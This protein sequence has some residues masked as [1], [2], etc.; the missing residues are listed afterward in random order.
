MERN[1][2]SSDITNEINNGKFYVLHRDHGFNDGSGWA[3][4]RYV[5]SDINKLNNDD[6]LPVVFSMNCFTGKFN[7][8]ECFAEAFIRRENGGCVGI[9]AASNESYSGYNDALVMGMFDAIWSNPGLNPEFGS[10]GNNVYIQTPPDIY[11][12]GDVLNHGLVRMEETWRGAKS[13]HQYSNEIFIYFGDPAM[14]IWTVQPSI[15]TVNCPTSISPTENSINLTNCSCSDALA[16]LLINEQLIDVVEF[17]NGSATLHF[18]SATY[19]DEAIITIS[20]SNHRPYIINIRFD[21]DL[22][23]PYVAILSPNNEDSVSGIISIFTDVYDK[24]SGIEKVEFHID[25]TLLFTDDNSPYQYD[26]NTNLYPSGSHTIKVIAF[27]NAGNFAED[28]ITVNIPYIPP[29]YAHDYAVIDVIADPQNPIVGESVNITAAIKNQGTS[30][31][32]AVLRLTLFEQH[33]I[34]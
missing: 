21:D 12:L 6:E 2:S 15:I 30:S 26:W 11:S 5:V 27:D 10:G 31:E 23:K 1:G 22:E 9:F 25:N 16:S 4:P 32:P 24:D 34:T 29:T 20:K 3:H 19:N 14:K 28:Y 8:D 13:Y 7:E 33:F 17:N 18:A